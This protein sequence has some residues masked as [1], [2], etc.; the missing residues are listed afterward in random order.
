MEK[1]TIKEHVER[2]KKFLKAPAYVIW[3]ECPYKNKQLI[4]LH[5]KNSS[6]TKS[7]DFLRHTF[8]PVCLS[9]I[10]LETKAT[11]GRNNSIYHCPCIVLGENEA[12]RITK[13]KI[14]GFKNG[15]TND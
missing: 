1:P 2:M 14:K 4:Y 7:I 8:C 12:V 10:G 9:F 11:R 3:S 6:L 5:K 15:S 13:K